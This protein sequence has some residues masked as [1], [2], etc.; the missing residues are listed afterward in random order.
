MQRTKF[1][2][3]GKTPRLVQV[4]KGTE[5]LNK[6]SLLKVWKKPRKEKTGCEVYISELEPRAVELMNRQYKK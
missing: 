6:P 2:H 1:L 5:P 4:L 3:S